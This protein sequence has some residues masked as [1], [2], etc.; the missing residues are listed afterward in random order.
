MAVCEV[1][2]LFEVLQVRNQGDFKTLAA[3][4]GN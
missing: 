4:R 3:I 2:E 1:A